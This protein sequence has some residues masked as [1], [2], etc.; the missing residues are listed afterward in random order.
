MTL[1][2]T[3]RSSCHSL[4]RFVHILQS[5]STVLSKTQPGPEPGN[6]VR[7]CVCM[8]ERWSAHTIDTGA[9]M[10]LSGPSPDVELAAPREEL[11]A[12]DRA[13]GVE[14]VRTR[15]ERLRAKQRAQRSR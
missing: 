3:I 15:E 6:C 4:T 12:L 10:R 9:R 14:P 5:T 7:V 11:R 2:Q 1:K 8:R 13:L